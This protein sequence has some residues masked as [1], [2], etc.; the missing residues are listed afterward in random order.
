MYSIQST[1]GVH[2]AV[3]VGRHACGVEPRCAGCERGARSVAEA[4]AVQGARHLGRLPTA[5]ERAGR[6]MGGA[7]G[8][9]V[10]CRLDVSASR[11]FLASRL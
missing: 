9:L 1:L 3:R 11:I 2:L 5:S 4:V 10:G 7:A 8:A 6:F